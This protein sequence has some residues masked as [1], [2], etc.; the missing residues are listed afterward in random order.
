MKETLIL[1]LAV[2]W[3]P[4][5]MAGLLCNET[6]FKKNLVIGVTLPYPARE[7]EAVQRQL[8]SFRKIQ[9]GLAAGLILAGLLCMLVPDALW[10]SVLWGTWLL[11]SCVAPYVVYA[12][13][14]GKLKALKEERGWAV[15]PSSEIT[16]DTAHITPANWQSPL[17]FL[18]P[19]LVS[20]LPLLWERVFL[21]VYL[22][23]AGLVLLFYLSYRFL[24][25]NRSERVDED[26][27]LTA[28]LTAIRRR[29]WGRMWQLSAWMM[30]GL[31]LVFAGMGNHPAAG[32]AAVLL[33]CVGMSAAIVWVELNTRSAQ[34][35][36]TAESGKG[37]YV[38]EDDLWLWGIFY[39]NPQDSHLLVNNRV[40][41]N[42]SFNLARPMGK[43][44]MGVLVALMLYLP[45][46][47]PLMDSVGEKAPEAALTENAI[48]VSSG[49]TAYTMER[50]DL[51]AAEQ[52]DTLPKDLVRV[53]GVGLPHLWKGDFHAPDLGRL[54]VCLDPTCPPFLLLT[55]SSGDQIL[56]GTRDAR[57]IPALH[58]ALTAE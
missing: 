23:D 46:C 35:R 57:E 22:M 25:R 17:L 13:W 45:F 26:Q 38:D 27:S 52:L 54:K 42:S 30:A 41:T 31:S 3:L 15:L 10:N 16:V 48:T 14:N 19:L 28:A 20:L 40:G 24:Y 18:L 2:L 56:L 11:V 53:M 44:L 50:S 4:I 51:A 7:D 12:R 39:Y 6:K 8:A 47:L 33:L 36:L 29:N 58:A 55:D 21:P 9:K 5:L 43:A 1:W 34:E 49:R 32:L 37:A